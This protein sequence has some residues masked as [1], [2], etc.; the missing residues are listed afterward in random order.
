MAD[1]R[2]YQK[3]VENNISVQGSSNDRH[4]NSNNYIDNANN[5][6]NNAVGINK[7]KHRIHH[8]P[9]HNDHDK[10]GETEL[11][12]ETGNRPT[13]VGKRLPLGTRRTTIVEYQAKTTLER[14]KDIDDLDIKLLNLLQRG[15]DNKEIAKSIENPLSTIQRRTRLIFERGLAALKVEPDYAKI[16]LKKGFLLIRLKGGK[17]PQIVERLRKIRGIVSISANI[18]SFPIICT[19]VYRDTTELW[20]IISSVQEQDCVKEV[21]WSE[22]IYTVGTEYNILHPPFAEKS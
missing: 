5:L 1:S 7:H 18:G 2:R 13:N 12:K 9:K 16:G 22:E 19:I 14:Q 15:Y 20:D 8:T 4:S 17:I 10:F 3:S 11:L 6:S 21:S